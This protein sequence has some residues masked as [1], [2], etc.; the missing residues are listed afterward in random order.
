MGARGVDQPTHSSSNQIRYK[1][2]KKEREINKQTRVS[3]G[4]RQTIFF[5]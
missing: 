2:K 5:F 4:E 1:R 3:N